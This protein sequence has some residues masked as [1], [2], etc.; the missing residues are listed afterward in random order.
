[1]I[2]KGEVYKCLISYENWTKGKSY[3]SIMDGFLQD[4]D[5]G[6]NVKIN[7]EGFLESYFKCIKEAYFSGSKIDSDKLNY[8]LDFEFITQIAERMQ[9]NKGKYEPYNWRKN[10]DIE[11]LKQAMFRHVLEVMKGNYKDDERLYGHLEAI[12][13]NAMFINYQLKNYESQVIKED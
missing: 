5:D 2:K 6:N 3:R 9:T 1:M 10:M 11:K 12:C 4:D 7:D 13:C 8:E